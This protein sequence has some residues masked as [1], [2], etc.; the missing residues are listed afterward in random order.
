MRAVGRQERAIER[1]ALWGMTKLRVD[2][3]RGIDVCEAAATTAM[4]V[5]GAK[6]A[7]VGS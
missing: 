1:E 5:M 7:G 3:G 6:R 2:G 4:A